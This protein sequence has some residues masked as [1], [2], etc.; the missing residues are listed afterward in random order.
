MTI[1]NAQQAQLAPHVATE[2]IVTDAGDNGRSTAES[3]GSDGSRAA[4][5][6]AEC[7]DI[8]QTHASLQ[9]IDVD[10]TSAE[11]H[12]FRPDLAHFDTGTILWM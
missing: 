2:R 3:G 11:S 10:A 5:V 7:L 1:V 6:F 8:F 12:H 9:R 4:K